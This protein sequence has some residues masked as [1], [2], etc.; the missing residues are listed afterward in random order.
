MRDDG[1]THDLGYPVGCQRDDGSI[2]VAYYFSQDD[3]NK[4]GGTRFL[5]GSIFRLETVGVNE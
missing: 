3:G 2:F 4:F 5:A 1:S